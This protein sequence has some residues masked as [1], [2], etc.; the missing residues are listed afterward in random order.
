MEL[1]IITGLLFAW[2]LL[3][4]FGE[5]ISEKSWPRETFKYVVWMGVPFIGFLVLYVGA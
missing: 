4:A 2:T 1:V 5:V 3:A